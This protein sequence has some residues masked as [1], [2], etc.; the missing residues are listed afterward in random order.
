MRKPHV[1]IMP[2]CVQRHLSLSAHA[3]LCNYGSSRCPLPPSKVSITPV[4]SMVYSTV[5][6]PDENGSPVHTGEGEVINGRDETSPYASPSV[7]PTDPVPVFPVTIP[8][9]HVP[10]FPLT[11]PDN[12]TPAFPLSIPDGPEP[13]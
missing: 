8:D 2:S 7:N 11:I 10:A 9:D 4:A 12:P 3:F 6:L 1:P 13:V 5:R